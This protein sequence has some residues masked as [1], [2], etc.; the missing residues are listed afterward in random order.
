MMPAAESIK[1]GHDCQVVQIPS[2]RGERLAAGTPVRVTQSMGSSYTIATEFGMMYRLD[3]GDADALGLESKQAEDIDGAETFREEMIREQL[4]TIYDPEIPVSIVDLGLVYSVTVV[5]LATEGKRIEIKMS[6]TA[7]GCGMS[8]VLKADV[9][10]KLLRLPEVREV[11][12]DVVFDP[13]WQPGMMS[14]AAKLQLGFD[15]DYGAPPSSSTPFKI[16]R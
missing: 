10:R 7:P 5:P 2:G 11:H 13:P 3:A 8:D 6:M 16:V 15:S 12:V 9:E 14:E 1:L 4:K